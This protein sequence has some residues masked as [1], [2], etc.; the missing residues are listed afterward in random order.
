MDILEKPR[1]RGVFHQYAFFVAL[2]A[3]IVLVALSD[4]V[5]ELVATW[6]YAAAL[7]AMFGVSALYHRVDWRS[8]RSRVWMRRLDHSMILLLIA[9]TYTPFALLAF[10]GVLADV[11]L[12]VVWAGAAAGLVL[13]LAWIDAPTWLTALVFV[14]LGWVGVARG[15]GAAS[16]SG[17]RRPSSSS[18]A[19]ASTRSARSRTRSS[20]RTRPRRRSATTRSSTCS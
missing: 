14:A 12:V 20:G 11:I 1:L 9:G 2:V 13:N 15:P 4:S 5:R 7:A 8:A 19:A 6:I 16:T 17:S 18:S 10:D 3:G